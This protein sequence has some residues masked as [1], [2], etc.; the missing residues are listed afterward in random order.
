[1]SSKQAKRAHR[2]LKR[3]KNN[4]VI[5]E[6][7]MCVRVIKQSYIQR[8]QQLQVKFHLKIQILIFKNINDGVNNTRLLLKL[9]NRV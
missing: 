5:P 4:A 6:R 8:V 1:M 9:S 7:D 2:G 3:D